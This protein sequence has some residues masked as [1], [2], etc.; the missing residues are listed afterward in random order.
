MAA[1]KKEYPEVTPYMYI[2]I[3]ALNRGWRALTF[4]MISKRLDSCRKALMNAS[5]YMWDN[6]HF[7]FTDSASK[8][9]FQFGISGDELHLWTADGL[10]SIGDIREED[11]PGRA[12]LVK[13]LEEWAQFVSDGKLRCSE[14]KKW[15]PKDAIISFGFTGVVCHTCHNPRIH[16]DPDL[17]GD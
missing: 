14:C 16:T 5:G 17:R 11:Y 9:V 10:H 3:T 1:K 6:S 2:H 7:I 4:D 12:D 13:T 15:F 8:A